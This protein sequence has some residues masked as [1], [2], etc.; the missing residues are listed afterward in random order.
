ML[1]V[2]QIS[3]SPWWLISGCV[4]VC[5]PVFSHVLQYMMTGWKCVLWNE[6]LK[7]CFASCDWWILV[8]VFL[9]ASMWETVH[10]QPFLSLRRGCSVKNNVNSDHLSWPVS[11]PSSLYIQ[12][13]APAITARV[14]QH[15][16]KAAMAGGFTIYLC[17]HTQ[18]AV[19]HRWCHLLGPPVI[20]TIKTE[21]AQYCQIMLDITDTSISAFV[22]ALGRYVKTNCRPWMLYRL[23]FHW[24]LFQVL[25]L[26]IIYCIFLVFSTVFLL[27]T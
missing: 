20:I 16:N 17:M 11:N 14:S 22:L 6:G 24:L 1:S 4:P 8:C 5:R 18:S 7:V 19:P 15:T 21:Q 13:E 10:Q 3:L 12:K 9:W 25:H 2:R 23:H 27:L 26:C